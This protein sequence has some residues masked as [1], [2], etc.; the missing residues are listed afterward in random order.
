MDG[1]PRDSREPLHLDIIFGPTGAGKSLYAFHKYPDAY[2]KPRGEWW[3][4]YTGEKVV[5]WDEFD[6]TQCHP[7]DFMQWFD[8]YPCKAPCKGGQA[9]LRFKHAVITSHKNPRGWWAEKPGTISSRFA[10]IKRRVEEGGGHIWY[11][12]SEEWTDIIGPI[13]E[14]KKAQKRVDLNE[15]VDEIFQPEWTLDDL[16]QQD[17][18][19]AIKE[20]TPDE[21]EKELLDLL[22]D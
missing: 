3:C 2:V 6:P 16:L 20:K 18:Q 8:R 4:G 13:L 5:I 1:T 7:R 11:T 17:K 9:N 15:W 12:E 21:V 10:E 19:V 14:E 22:S